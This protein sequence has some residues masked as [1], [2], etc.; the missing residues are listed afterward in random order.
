MSAPPLPDRYLT[1]D[2][3]IRHFDDWSSSITA[4]VCESDLDHHSPKKTGLLD[5]HGVPIMRVPA[6]VPFGFIP[7][8][9]AGK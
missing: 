6:S 7:P 4:D 5:Q 2:A 3:Y 9:K 8:A 1:L